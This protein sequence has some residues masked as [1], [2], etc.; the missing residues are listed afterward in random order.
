M[1]PSVEEIK[2]E[3]KHISVLVLDKMLPF[4]ETLWSGKS[5]WDKIKPGFIGTRHSFLWVVVFTV[6][7][8]CPPHT[9][10][11]MMLNIGDLRPQMLLDV[12][13]GIRKWQKSLFSKNKI[14]KIKKEPAV[15]LT[16]FIHQ[17]FHSFPDIVW[18]WWWMGPRRPD[19]AALTSELLVLLLMVGPCE[20][21]LR[22]SFYVCLQRKLWEHETKLLP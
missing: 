8:C 17:S 3:L 18:Y 16:S 6:Q 11:L 15:Y 7:V 4:Y 13:I 14:L 2:R 21:L 1:V 19:P 12:W 9:S 5:F 10:S 22:V 20:C